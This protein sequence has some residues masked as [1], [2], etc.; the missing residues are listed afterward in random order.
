MNGPIVHPASWRDVRTLTGRLAEAFR[1]DPLYRWMFGGDAAWRRKGRPFFRLL[2]RVHLRDGRVFTNSDLSGAALWSSPDLPY[3]GPFTQLVLPLHMRRLFAERADAVR[4]EIGR[5][6]AA[7]PV[8]PHWYLPVL[9]V[10]PEC[11]RTGIGT[12]LLRPV[13]DRCDKTGYRAYLETSVPDNIPF[14]GRLGF[15]VTDEMEVEGGPRVWGMVREPG[16][17]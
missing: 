10:T 12:A 14:Y 11:Q 13:L 8:A 6:N 3:G 15:G 4:W 16:T 7:R 17:A 9:G 5:L 1:D 2:L